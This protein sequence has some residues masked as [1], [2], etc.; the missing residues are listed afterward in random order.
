[1]FASRIFG[2][3]THWHPLHIPHELSVGDDVRYA[4]RFRAVFRPSGRIG[5]G[6]HSLSD[7]TSMTLY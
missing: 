7:A 1:M 6:L 2:D 4:M 3:T 5:K